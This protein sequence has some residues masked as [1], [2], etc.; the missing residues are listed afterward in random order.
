MQDMVCS[1]RGLLG[2]ALGLTA[3]TL[4]GG[5]KAFA[6]LPERRI[7]FHNVHTNER[8]DARYYTA[9]VGYDQQGLAEINHALRDW[10]TNEQTRMD[11]E[12]MDLLV[13]IRTKL[14][15]DPKKAFDLISGYRSPATNAGLRAKGG[16]HTGVASKSQHM[17]GKATDI[18]MPGVQLATL[19]Q[20]AVSMQRGGVGFYPRDNFV[21]VDTA[22]VRTW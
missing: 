20:A 15:L 4:M 12:L 10:R 1:R 18:Y 8:F 22:R 13:A 19:R 9:G 7:A 5:G 17:L 3:A 11:P 14:E 2:G 16:A 6:A 21:H